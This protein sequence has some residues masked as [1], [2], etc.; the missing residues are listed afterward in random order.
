[1]AMAYIIY[2]GPFL[3][4][5]VRFSMQNAK[6]R[7]DHVMSRTGLEV[8]FVRIQELSA[9]CQRPFKSA[10]FASMSSYRQR[11]KIL[12]Q[13]LS[14]WG[15]LDVPLH[16]ETWCLW[17]PQFLL[18]C[19]TGWSYLDFWEMG[20]FVDSWICSDKTFSSY[21]RTKSWPLLPFCKW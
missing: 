15:Q 5:I 6:G 7:K 11:A 13:C 17:C 2:R 10:V 20:S 21:A 8:S 9:Y 14:N 4:D 16:L 19:V 3:G 12:S 18:A 1:M